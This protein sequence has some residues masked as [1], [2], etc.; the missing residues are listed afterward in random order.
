VKTSGRMV[1]L[2]PIYKFQHPS[3]SQ[4]KEF[5]RNMHS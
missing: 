4:P 5:D 1:S 3:Q 2:H